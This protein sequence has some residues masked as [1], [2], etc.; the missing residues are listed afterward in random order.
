MASSAGVLGV[1]GEMGLVEAEPDCEEDF[2]VFGMV[3]VA[4]GLP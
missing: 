3:I 2:L 4:L 1:T